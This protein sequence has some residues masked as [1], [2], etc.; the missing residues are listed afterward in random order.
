[1]QEL[2]SEQIQNMVNKDGELQAMGQAMTQKN[3]KH[4]K[5]W[6]AKMWKIMVGKMDQIQKISPLTDKRQKKAHGA[7]TRRKRT[8]GN[9]YSIK[10]YG[11][12][13]TN[14]KSPI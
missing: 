9:L 1:M 14:E 6:N 3:S 13:N 11:G 2:K 8:G 10:S 7:D 4:I 5:Q 12:E